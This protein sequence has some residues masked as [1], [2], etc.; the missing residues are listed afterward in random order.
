MGRQRSPDRDKAFEIYRE[1]K[2][3]ITNRE[4]ANILNE[5]EKKVAVW[6]QRDKWNE[7][8]NVVRQKNESCTT[9]KS[10]KNNTK[11]KESVQSEVTEIDNPELNVKQRLF[12]MYYVKY[13]NKTKAYIKA[14][15][16]SYENAHA[17]AYKLWQN[18]AVKNE[19]DKQ[20]RELRD[21]LKLDVQDLI[22]KY[23][24]IAFADITDFVVFGQEEVPVM[25]AFGPVVDE[26][27]NQVT[28]MVNTVKFR[29][30]TNVDGTLISEI[31]QGKDGAKLKLYDKMKA[32]DWLSNH[33]D[34]LDTATKEK[35][36]LE[37]LKISGGNGE[38]D[39]SGVEEFIKATTMSEEDIKEL[40]KDDIDE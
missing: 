31:G 37:K 36:K 34:L 7:K 2:G 9:K 25:G 10:N 14:Y 17:N 26:D 4:I 15:Q 32:L 20:L 29:T 24:D 11:N 28:R 40:F 6:K 12:C 21:E 19:I 39:K 16:C 33:M 5:D 23:I 22:Q 1:H 38:S 13:R 27:G 3:N 35:L 8:I 30:W 18:M